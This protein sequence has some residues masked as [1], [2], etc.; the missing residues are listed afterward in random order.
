MRSVASAILLFV[1]NIIGMGLGPYVVG[2]LSDLLH[3]GFGIQ[4]LRYALCIAVIANL[5]ATV[6]YLLAAQTLR[7]DLDGPHQT[8][9]RHELA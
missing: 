7:V 6:H 8:P 3:P 4:S 9:V 1:I 5:W 2:I